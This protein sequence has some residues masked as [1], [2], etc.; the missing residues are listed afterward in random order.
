MAQANFSG[1]E[2]YLLPGVAL[3]SIAGAVGWWKVSTHTG[4]NLHHPSNRTPSLLVLTPILAV[5]VVVAAAPRIADLPDLRT[6][7]IHQRALARDLDEAIRRAGGSQ[8]VLACGT[9][10]VGPLRGPLMAYHLDVPKRDVE[11]DAL[12]RPP[13]VV[14]RARLTAASPP[15]PAAAAPF[16]A[17]GRTGEW[18]VLAA[19]TRN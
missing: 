6:A 18:E 10:Y 4:V 11:P 5:A 9:P 1:E 12:P 17:M 19:C 2:R 13:G 14:F 3:L 7:Q 8:V 15:A 16:R